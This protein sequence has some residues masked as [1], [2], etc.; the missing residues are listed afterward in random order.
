MVTDEGRMSSFRTESPWCSLVLHPLP[1]QDDVKSQ[2]RRSACGSWKPFCTTSLCGCDWNTFLQHFPTSP[3]WLPQGFLA[4]SHGDSRSNLNTVGRRDRV[5]DT[6]A[7]TPA[8]PNIL[9]QPTCRLRRSFRRPAPAT[10]GSMPRQQ[11]GIKTPS[12]I[13]QASTLARPFSSNFPACRRTARRW[14]CW[15]SAAA[16]AC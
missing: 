4:T 1:Y 15:R 12:S 16:R 6:V 10:S 7:D 5:H 2:V 8:I 9:T 14:T 13:R 3:H 11:H